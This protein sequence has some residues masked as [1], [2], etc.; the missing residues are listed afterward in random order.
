M[1]DM[2]KTGSPAVRTGL[3]VPRHTQHHQTRIG[4]AQHVPS[5]PPLL[6]RTGAKVFDQHVR[7]RHQFEE[8]FDPFPLTQVD[9]HRLAVTRLAQPGERCVVT[10]GRGAKTPHRV[11]ANRVFDLQHLRAELPQDRRCIRTGKKVAYVDNPNTA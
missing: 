2:C 5:Q 4:F 10:G 6:H 11:A 1:R 7:L 9:G 8:Q 3:T